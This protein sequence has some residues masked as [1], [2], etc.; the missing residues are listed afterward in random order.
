VLVLA[1]IALTA[2]FLIQARKLSRT[3]GY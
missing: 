3:Q 1:L 2:G